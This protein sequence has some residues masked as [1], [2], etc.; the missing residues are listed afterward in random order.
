MSEKIATPIVKNKF[1]VVQEQGHKIATIQAKDDGGI[2]YVHDDQREYFDTVNVLKKKYNIKF[3][4]FK[5]PKSK[6]LSKEVYG[7]PIT[8]RSFNEVYDVQNKIP[9]YTKTAKSKSRYCAGYYLV[10][11]NDK[12][13]TVF[14]PKN[15]TL[16]RYK[17]LGPYKTEK[18][19]NTNLQKVLKNAKY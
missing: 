1:W 6:N 11:I 5:K 13:N 10:N 19:Q 4:G 8:G 2:V 16:T 17:F 7:F 18:E 3:D 15:I 14:C 12:W 9:L